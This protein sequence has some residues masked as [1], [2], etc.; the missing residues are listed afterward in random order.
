MEANISGVIV[1]GSGGQKLDTIAPITSSAGISVLESS[2]D[3]RSFT[4]VPSPNQL[5]LTTTSHHCSQSDMELT[6]N[7]SSPSLVIQCQNPTPSTSKSGSVPDTGKGK[8]VAMSFTVIG[9]GDSTSSGGVV[10]NMDIVEAES[11]RT[12]ETRDDDDDGNVPMLLDKNTSCDMA[13]TPTSCD[14]AVTLNKTRDVTCFGGDMTLNES[15]DVSGGTMAVTLNKN[16]SCDMAMTLNKTRDVSGDNM[17]VTLNKNTSCDMAMTLNKTR[18]ATCFSDDNMA[19]TLNKT[20]DATCFGGDMTLN[21]TGDVSG[22][23]MTLNKTTSC[24]MA[25]TLIKTRDA[26]CFGG[27]MIMEESSENITAGFD[28][29]ELVDATAVDAD[30]GTG[31]CGKFELSTAAS[32]SVAISTLTSGYDHPLPNETAN[33]GATNAVSAPLASTPGISAGKPPSGHSTASKNKRSSKRSPARRSEAPP[34]HCSEVRRSPTRR[35]EVCHSPTRHSKA[36]PTRHSEAPPTERSEASHSEAPPIRRSEARHS[37]APPTRH[38]EAPP[39]RRSETSHSEAPPTRQSEASQSEAPLTRRSETSHSEAP[40]T[41][42]SHSEAPPTRQSEASHSEAPPTRRSEA[43]HSEARRSETPELVTT[44]NS[45]PMTKKVP[46]KNDQS[47]QSS[48]KK[49][50]VHIPH[51]IPVRGG[52]KGVVSTPLSKRTPRRKANISAGYADQRVT[53]SMIA[54][55]QHQ[56]DH[57][58]SIGLDS[59]VSLHVDTTLKDAVMDKSH[60]DATRIL[61]PGRRRRQTPFKT[62]GGFDSS[63]TKISLT[64]VT[65]GTGSQPT[66]LCSV[67]VSFDGSLSTAEVGGLARGGVMGRA[68]DGNWL[69]TQDTSFSL[70][71]SSSDSFPTDITLPERLAGISQPG[72]GGPA[73]MSLPG[74]VKEVSPVKSTQSGRKRKSLSRGKKKRNPLRASLIQKLKTQNE[75]VRENVEVDTPEMVP[76]ESRDMA[77]PPQNSIFASPDA[78]VCLDESRYRRQ[79]LMMSPSGFTKFLVNLNCDKT[80]GEQD[81]TSCPAA[82]VEVTTSADKESESVA[83]LDGSGCGHTAGGLEGTFTKDESQVT[84]TEE[85]VCTGQM[86]DSTPSLAEAEED[87]VCTG[88]AQDNHI[89]FVEEIVCTE[90]VFTEEVPVSS[91]QPIPHTPALAVMADGIF[92]PPLSQIVP[93]RVAS[94]P[95]TLPAQ[96]GVSSAAPPPSVHQSPVPLPSPSPDR[97]P[98]VSP[99]TL[100]GSGEEVMNSFNSD[101]SSF[102]M[103]LHFLRIK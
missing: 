75:E 26:T 34:T 101:S 1:S 102:I 7:E 43:S 93:S 73:D 4:V 40:P 38:S 46:V 14:M 6:L 100:R 91:V 49:S 80:L 20:R 60:A 67:G 32:K 74:Q 54:A 61:Q 9:D 24:D 59:G 31:G 55:S 62:S 8:S 68:G 3:A 57:D 87:V 89:P 99:H 96:R 70:V 19:I 5:S 86:G 18:N 51:R 47:F 76:V 64:N 12:N 2:Q 83:L 90:T 92:T 10:S 30:A 65:P 15:R 33:A 58:S 82:C 45:G 71:N 77:P 37:E 17:A 88:L 81:F 29:M 103:H 69:E 44:K 27:D 39:T 22:E 72:G 52:P 35:S 95:C 21:E 23:A 11:F 94:H 25:M 56:M 42:T 85:V 66:T 97:T 41:Q 16:T 36:P 79:S 63:S 84:L 53:R 50:L 48:S 28:D 13:M 78:T 98:S